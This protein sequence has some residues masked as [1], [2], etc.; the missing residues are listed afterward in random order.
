M[1]IINYIV[2]CLVFGT[3]FLAIKVGVDASV[4]PFFFAGIRFFLAGLFL[5]SWMAYRQSASFKLLLR[6]E[7]LITGIC[8]TFATFSTLYWAEQYIASGVAAILSATGPLMILLLQLALFRLR[9]TFRSAIGCIVG[10]AGVLLLM[11]PELT[12]T[13]NRW[14]IV[15]SIAVLVGELFYC[16]GTLYSRKV[17]IRLPEASPIAI[18]AVQMMYGGVLLLLL[19]AFTEHVRLASLLSV[20]AMGSL[21][22][23]IVIGSMIGHSLYYWLVVKTNPVFPAT[24]LYVSPLIALIVGVL[25]YEEK[26]STV[27]LFGVATIIVGT[28]VVNWDSLKE[29]LVGRTTS[30]ERNQPSQSRA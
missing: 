10:F 15:G 17:I 20:P 2:I 7:L 8:L 13:T 4:P 9:P 21:L 18:N 26:I 19:S 5:F 6:K 3:T 1:I 12:I 23:L 29:I 16:L 28:V 11:L 30:L 27:S 24:W 25:L 22:Y 14:W